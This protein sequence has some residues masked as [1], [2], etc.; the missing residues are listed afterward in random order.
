[1]D[2]HSKVCSRASF[3]PFT[4]ASRMSSQVAALACERNALNFHWHTQGQRLDRNTAP[5]RLM[6]KVLAIRLVHLLEVRHV[7]QEDVDLDHA[8][9]RAA[10]LIQDRLDVLAALSC[11]FADVAFHE[12]AVWCAWDLAGD[13]DGAAGDDGLRLSNP[14]QYDVRLKVMKDSR[15]ARRRGTPCPCELSAYPPCSFSTAIDDVLWGDS[16]V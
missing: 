11:L 15:R 13:E 10:C 1:M 5:R 2:S 7:I 4:F 3:R 8:L 6:R 12:L 9:D 14:C 16:V